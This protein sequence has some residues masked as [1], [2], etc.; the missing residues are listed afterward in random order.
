MGRTCRCANRALLVALSVGIGDD[1]GPREKR[2]AGMYRQRIH[3]QILY[4]QFREYM[5]IAEEVIALRRKLG[6][7]TP[8][9]WAPVFGTGNEV[10]WEIE[11]GDL[12]TFERENEAFYSDAEVME[13][14]RRL[15]QHAVQGSIQDE[16]LQEAPR[17]A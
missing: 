2:E 8:V 3:Q 7:A 16:L 1:E 12:A 5:E 14:W 10:V 13:Q 17:I 11:Y 9:L 6:L 4:G 15:W